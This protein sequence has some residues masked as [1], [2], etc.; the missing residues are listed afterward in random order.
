[1]VKIVQLEP[2]IAAAPQLADADFGDIAARGFRSVVNIRPDGEAPGQLA[3]A[4][5]KRTAVRH[6]LTFRHLPVMSVNVTDEDVV[7]EFARMMDEL[8][9]PI[10]FYCGS[11]MRSTTLWAQVAAPRLGVDAVLTAAREGGFDLEVLRDT[12]NESA[13]WL[14]K[15]ERELAPAAQSCS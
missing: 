10:L 13:E 7:E 6:G 12:L 2:G 14:G 4:Q 9:R 15:P 1:M 5:A 8:P 11:A 3:N